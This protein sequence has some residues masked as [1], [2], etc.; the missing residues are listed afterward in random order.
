MPPADLISRAPALVKI[1]SAT[2]RNIDPASSGR[3]RDVAFHKLATRDSC[4]VE[5]SVLQPGLTRSRLGDARPHEKLWGLCSRRNPQPRHRAYRR[6]PKRQQPLLVRTDSRPSVST[7]CKDE[8]NH[9]QHNE[10]NKE[11]CDEKQRH[12]LL[13]L[14]RR[15][16]LQRRQRRRWRRRQGC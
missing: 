2:P 9:H 16:T 11:I 10:H 7:T 1:C 3:T 5:L 12:V 6:S 15:S 4:E 14:A 8:D 13:Q